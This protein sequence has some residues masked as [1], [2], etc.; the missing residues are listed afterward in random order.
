MLRQ[1]PLAC[2]RLS[3]LLRFR[4]NI[5]CKFAFFQLG[6]TG[7]SLIIFYYYYYFTNYPRR[8]PLK[9]ERPVRS[10]M[11]TGYYPIFYNFFFLSSVSVSNFH[12]LRFTGGAVVLGNKKPILVHPFLTGKK[13]NFFTTLTLIFVLLLFQDKRLCHQQLVASSIWWWGGGIL[14][15]FFF[16]KEKKRYTTAMIFFY[17]N[18]II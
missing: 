16:K 4:T 5:S 14:F 10:V 9:F 8:N 11:F 17:N 13:I 3:R 6:E 12:Y 18:T 15:F 2:I 7:G 1:H